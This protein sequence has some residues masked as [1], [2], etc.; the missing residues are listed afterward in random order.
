M[1]GCDRDAEKDFG[2]T[3]FFAKFTTGSFAKLLSVVTAISLSGYA[4]QKLGRTISKIHS[5]KFGKNWLSSYRQEY[6]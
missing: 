6:I 5:T 2:R 4:R 3:T 1:F